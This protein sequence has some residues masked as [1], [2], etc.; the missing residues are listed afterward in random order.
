[1]KLYPVTSFVL[2]TSVTLLASVNASIY[3]NWTLVKAVID[4]DEQAAGVHHFATIGMLRSLPIRFLSNPIPGN[5]LKVTYNRHMTS[6]VFEMFRQFNITAEVL[7]H[8]LQEFIENQ[9]E[10]SSTFN[11][12]KY[13]SLD[14]IYREMHRLSSKYP[15]IVSQAVIGTSVEGRN[16]SVLQLSFAKSKR[17]V[18]F[19]ECAAHAREWL[20]VSVCFQFIRKLFHRKPL[21]VDKFDIHIVPV[22]NVDGYE[23]SWRVDRL[24]RKNR[25]KPVL[26]L[27]FHGVDL[28]RNFDVEFKPFEEHQLKGVWLDLYPGQSAFDQPETRAI[29]DYIGNL[30]LTRTVAAYFSVHMFSQLWLYPLSYSRNETE[31]EEQ[32]NFLS[33]L[34]CQRIEEKTGLRYQPGNIARTLYPASGTSVDWAFEGA[35][36]KRVFIIELRDRGQQ[37]FLMAPEQIDGA[38]DDLYFGAEAILDWMAVNELGYNLAGDAVRVSQILFCVIVTLQ[39]ITL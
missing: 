21:F 36:I 18:V 34:A 25:A 7:S 2:Y 13:N 19:F 15:K 8:D 28:N 38:G 24:W 3:R 17:P 26:N 23:Y 31:H 27:T 6:N 29:R 5:T 4:N 20:A 39:L 30:S 10:K 22:L 11:Y 16:I 12:D 32:L 33:R 37:G 14:N 9:Q 1:M 35:N